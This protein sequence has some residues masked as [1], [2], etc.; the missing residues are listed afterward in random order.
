MY[1]SIHD[2]TKIE[3]VRVMENRLGKRRYFTRRISIFV[4]ETEYQFTCFSGDRKALEIVE[5]KE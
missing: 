3:I 1:G 5:V 2:V 4:G